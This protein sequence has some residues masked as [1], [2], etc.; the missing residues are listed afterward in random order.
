MKEL[1]QLAWD[2][3]LFRHESY[4]QHAARADALKRGLA[5]VVLV[6]LLAGLIPFFINVVGDL[7]P[8]AIEARRQEAEEGMQEFTQ[9]LAAMRQLFDVPPEFERQMTAYMRAGMRIGSRIEALPTRLPKPVGRV[10]QDLG[11]FLSLPFSRLAG[12]IGYSIWVLLVAKLLGGRATASQMLGATALYA[13]PHVLEILDF[14]PCLGA[15]LGLVAVVW[16][17]A[18]YVKAL[19]VANDFSMGRATVATVVPALIGG[20]LILLGL[21]GVLILALVSR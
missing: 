14:V 20:A 7:R 15:T 17:I 5:L 12:W 18:I 13:V 19:A 10:L 11:A 1:L 16:G 3:L 4:V 8:M 2:V 21:M 9:S 6:A